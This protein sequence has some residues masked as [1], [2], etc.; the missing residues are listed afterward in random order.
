MI[1][2][3][4]LLVGCLVA[5]ESANGRIQLMPP[6]VDHTIWDGNNISTVHGN[7]GDVASYH[8]TGQPG[9]VW[10]KE[11]NISAVFQ[12]GLWLVA[13]KI[14][15][16]IISNYGNCVLKFQPKSQPV[17]TKWGVVTLK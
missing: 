17:K 7:H 5:K 8:M 12:D 14:N 13:G 11:Q 2:I 6:E 1:R 10:P 4:I 16:Q 3:F 9:L 15:G